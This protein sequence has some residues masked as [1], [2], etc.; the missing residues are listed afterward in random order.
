MAFEN[1]SER[2]K[3]ILLNLIDYYIA[4][5]DPVGS[6]VIANKFKMGISSA[7]VRNTLQDLEELGLVE[8]PHTSAGRIPTDIGYR[9]YVDYLL[10]PEKLT[11]AEQQQIKQSIIKE[12]RGINELLGQTARV[13]GEITQ[14]LGVTISPKFESGRL[15]SLRLIRIAEGKIMVV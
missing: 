3:Q 10:R 9:V 13:L 5:A 15:E 8:Q 1:L 6:R 2:E 11:Q 4:S 12:G 14:Q 7:T